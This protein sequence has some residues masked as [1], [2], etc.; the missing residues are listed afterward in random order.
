MDIRQMRNAVRAGSWTLDPEGQVTA[1][2]E[3]QK[4]RLTAAVTTAR[5]YL[6]GDFTMEQIGTTLGVTAERAA[7][8]VRLG[9][10]YMKTAGW[11]RP[12]L[13]GAPR[14]HIRP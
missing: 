9:I 8:V 1:R 6:G 11:L 5:L 13:P 2:T 10:N 3:F 4:G 14:L 12:A 7:Q